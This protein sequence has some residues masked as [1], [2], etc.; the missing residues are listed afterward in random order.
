MHTTTAA[1]A[2]TL[3]A[4]LLAAPAAAGPAAVPLAGRDIPVT[5]GAA[6]GYV[7]DRACAPCHRD[8][9]SSYQE[10][11]MARS[12]FR[13]AAAN[14]IETWGTFVHEPSARHYEMRRSGERLVFKRYQLDAEGQPINVFE[15]DVDWVLGSG[16][17]SRTYLYHTPAGELYQLP[18]AWYSQ[19]ASWNMA[20]GF[21]RRFHEGIERRVRREC[22]FC[23]NAYPDVPAGSDL[24]SAQTYPAQLPEG[25]GC[26]RCHGP[27]AEHVRL[28]SGEDIDFQQLA[29][30]IVNPADLSPELAR[31]VCYQCH[32]QPSV[33][34]P[35]IRRFDRGDYSYRP[36]EP[37]SDYLVQV[38]V[39]VAGKTREE[40][41]E[42]N[43]HAYR[44]EQ[45]RCFIASAG[46]L[47]CTSCHDPHRKVQ[48]AERAAHYRAACA[49]CHKVDDCTL[50][51]MKAASPA[52]VAP[53]AVAPDDCAT[54]H[55]PKH[56]TQD[57]VHAVMTDHRIR[58][59]P[60]GEE[61]LA[62]L[63]ETESTMT[64]LALLAPE[65]VGGVALG[66]LYRAVAAARA[67]GGEAVVDRLTKTLAATGPQELSPY[68]DLGRGQLNYRR[69]KDA[70]LTFH[71]IL[72]RSPGHPLAHEWLGLVMARGGR[73]DQ[74]LAN[75]R[76]ALEASP[77]RPETSFNLGRLLF[78]WDQAAES[79]APLERAVELRP[80]MVAGWYFLASAQAALGRHDDAAA[81]YRRA[82]EL[83]PTYDRAYVG[84]GELLLEQGKRAEALRY[85]RHG[86]N[87]ARR[88]QA[89]ARA[90]ALA[91]ASA[92]AE[93]SAA[94]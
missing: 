8:L 60:G 9:Y 34:L 62:P 15:R 43:H 23:H 85:L 89:V 31:D 49:Q 27:G 78:A 29:A 40:R 80:N 24:A 45:S 5:G 75:L 20:P 41:F 47:S 39:S 30:A 6:P 55:M 17:V 11:G 93:A 18:I 12:F 69:L 19:T 36:G 53:A 86:A 88:S 59:Q 25:T 35:G 46:E 84:L 28:A 26:Q 79:V 87:I 58:R 94:D 71:G 7:P 66:E 77:E 37:L 56:R 91:E 52:A 65:R 61:L 57:V 16:G 90:L 3:L 4:F 83:D 22:M 44:L 2:N 13:P 48:P 21:D 14:D 38:D 92:E 82:L 64:G 70:E 1:L 76:Q 42:I 10:V 67:G 33:E 73:R 54:C 72:E 68:L 81:G 51:E 63:I 32:M 74:A 50:E